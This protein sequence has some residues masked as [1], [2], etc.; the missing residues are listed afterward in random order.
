MRLSHA[1][2]AVLLALP[3]IA[4]GRE[5]VPTASAP[6]PPVVRDV[7][8]GV[9]SAA[10]LDETAEVTGT[11]KA[12]RTTTLSSNVT[13]RVVALHAQEGTEV[14]VGQVLV[15]LDDQ[16]IAS[17]LR[18]AE[19]GLRET[20][21]AVTETDRAIAAAAAGKTAAEAQRA[22]AVTTLGRYQRL[23]ERKSIAP[24]EYDQIAAQQKTATAAVERADAET[25]VVQSKRTQ[26]LARI[27][28][29]KAE[30]AGIRVLR[31]YTKISAPFDGVVTGK[32]TEVGGLAA[33]GAPLLT[34]EAQRQYW[35][36]LSIPDAQLAPLKPGQSVRSAVE[37]AGLAVNAP[38]S[39]ILPSADPATRSTLVRLNLPASPRLRSGQFGRA[40]IPA[41]RRTAL[42]VPRTAVIE[43]G[44]L[45][46]V[47]VVGQDRIARFRLIRIGGVHP[48]GV[49]VLSGLT[50]GEQ[51]V[52]RGVE[53][54]SD[55]ARIAAG[56]S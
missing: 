39:E 52:L 48:G 33:P 17:Q 10:S 40:W 37:A 21:A 7:A 53:R 47:Y 27:D 9:I 5:P 30:I 54:V 29:A 42:V 32:H 28:A 11:V 41:G 25:Q 6:E 18:R 20:E 51:V 13:G 3:L 38:I 44:Q 46:G 55:G 26:V 36:E 34:L 35:L 1:I 45:Q 8:I 19:A 16:D 23:L 14:R 50:T 2:L 56:P 22:L 43:R 24:V 4:C 15:E 49:E 12:R 31:G